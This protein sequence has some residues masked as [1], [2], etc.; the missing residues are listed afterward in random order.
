MLRSLVDVAGTNTAI[1][2]SMFHTI[3]SMYLYMIIDVV[4]IIHD[5]VVNSLRSLVCPLTP[6]LES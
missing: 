6:P 4:G 5:V 2:S 1:M 3:V